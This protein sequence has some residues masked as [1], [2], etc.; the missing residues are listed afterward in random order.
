MIDALIFVMAVTI[1][2]QPTI[3]RLCVALSFVSAISLHDYLLSNH[4]GLAYY[5]SAALF[6][7]AI[8]F[9]IRWINPISLMS[10]RLSMISVISIMLNFAGWILWITYQPPT[11]Y[12][13]AFVAL[14][15]ISILTLIKRDDNV[16]NNTVDKWT[17][18]LLHFNPKS[19]DAI[20]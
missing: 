13:Y 19:S 15:T 16:G 14:Y 9:F 4:E 11:I 17:S 7:L 8:M 20:H 10:L 1:L 18:D 3:K 6:D 5:G 12:N 2:F